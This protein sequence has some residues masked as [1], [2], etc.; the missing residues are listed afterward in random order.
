[1]NSDAP[2]AQVLECTMIR[3]KSLFSAFTLLAVVL[4]MLAG[5][6]TW[7]HQA[8]PASGASNDEMSPVE[9]VKEVGPAVV[10]VINEQQ[11][12]DSLGQDA[13]QLVPV[14]SGSGFIIDDKGH[15]VT[16]NH[17]VEGGQ[18][19]DVI[20]ADGTKQSADLVGADPTSDLAVVKVSGD[21]PDSVKLGDS[22]DLEPGQSVLA[23]GSPLG[24]FTNTV[25]DGIVSGLGRSLPQQGGGTVYTNLIQHDAPINP[26]NS[27]GPLFDLH[28]DV[29]GVNTIAIPMA[30]QGVPAQGLFFAIPSN[31]V[32]K[33]THQLIETGHVVYPFLGVS[34]PVAIDPV[35]A[36]QNGLPVDHGVYI[37]DV[38]PDSPAAQAGLQPGDVV[39]AI[40]GEPI[41][42]NHPLEE[43]LFEH[44][45]GDTVELTVQR[46][47]DELKLKVKLGERPSS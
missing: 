32:K 36:A 9:L 11:V 4:L 47:K 22:N 42:Q 35:V 15:V 14:G 6:T 44:K 39:T 43:F 37:A 30:E 10:T 5:V 17:V 3:K 38:A 1:M 27:G 7:F 29:V 34:N 13:S 26:G 8:S 12:G 45:P 19:F 18:K 21:V 46:G 31:T 20:Y 40:D 24:A 41:D 28:G 16:N 23:M 25:T 33:I 2:A